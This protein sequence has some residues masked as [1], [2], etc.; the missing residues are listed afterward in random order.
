MRKN[1]FT[2]PEA[3]GDW[4]MNGIDST[5]LPIELDITG[6]KRLRFIVDYGQNLD[7]GDWLNLGNVRVV[8]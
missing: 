1:S 7:T 2:I 5:P 4:K 3:F 8:K 6:V